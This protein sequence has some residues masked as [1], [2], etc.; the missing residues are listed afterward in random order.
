MIVDAH[1][2]IIPPIGRGYGEGDAKLQMKF[3]QHE[4]RRR[5]PFTRKSDGVVVDEALMNNP[6]SDDMNDLPDVNLRMREYGK[7][8][9]TV[10]GVDYECQVWEYARR[11]KVRDNDVPPEYGV[12]EMDRVG[13]D[14]AVLQSDHLYT[15]LNEYYGEAMRNYPNRFIG[16]SQI[17][18]WE[19]EQPAQLERLE[20]SI[21]E[22]GNKGLY[23]RTE[24]LPFGHNYLLADDPNLEPLWRKVRELNIPVWWYLCSTRTK[25]RYAGFLEHLAAMDRW[26]QRHPEI[27]AVLTHGI[28]SLRI[29]DGTPRAHEIPDEAMVL[30]RRPNVHV[31]IMFYRYWP[32]YPFIGAQQAVKRL[33]DELGP[34]KIMWGSD[35]YIVN[36]WCTYEQSLDYIRHSEILSAEGRSLIMGG[37]AA[38]MFNLTA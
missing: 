11:H 16:L 20:R 3:F 18:E 33:C 32:P 29:F 14:M 17:Y 1:F 27:P 23:F 7:G 31:E 10:D 30:L 22:Q 34:E 25:N 13:V 19:A 15:S 26:A 12:A 2:H 5:R 36:L 38:R 24:P 37:N 9:I 21:L 4:V 8:D 6:D 28:D 35:H